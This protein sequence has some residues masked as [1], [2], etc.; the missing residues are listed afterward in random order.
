LPYCD[1]T[2]DASQRDSTDN[3]SP[4]DPTVAAPS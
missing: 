3:L 1:F 2:A 4:L